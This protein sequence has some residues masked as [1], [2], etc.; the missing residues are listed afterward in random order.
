MG[1]A[2]IFRA[3]NRAHIDT[4]LAFSSTHKPKLLSSS[5]I[6]EA[7]LRLLERRI[8]TGPCNL[9]PVLFPSY[10]NST[11]TAHWP[12]APLCRLHHLRWPSSPSSPY[13]SVLLTMAGLW[14]P[15]LG[16]CG[17]HPHKDANLTCLLLMAFGLSYS[18]RNKK[19]RKRK[20]TGKNTREKS[21]YYWKW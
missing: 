19:E 6:I 16:T 3:K 14:H 17:V 4:I 13:M 8:M 5:S 12:C 20:G 1:R 15:A 21:L 7:S 11:L 2:A 18:R 10:S 9:T